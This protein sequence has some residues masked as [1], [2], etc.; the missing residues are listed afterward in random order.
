ML[1]E[2]FKPMVI[3][4]GLINFPAMFQTMM[5][6]ILQDLIN[7]GKVVNFIDDIIVRKEEAKEHNKVVEKVVKRLAENDLY[8]K[9][10]KVKM[11]EVL[12]WLT[13][14]RVK[15][16]QKFLGLANYYQWFIKDFT[17]ITGLTI[18]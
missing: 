18:I 12:N 4:F 9:L 11:K 1:E 5:N 3:F 17:S 15:G 8:V 2:S 14:K 10:E 7:T 16:I 13:P 6:K